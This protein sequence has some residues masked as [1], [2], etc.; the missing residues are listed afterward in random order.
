MLHQMFCL[1]F[2]FTVG[3]CLK[4]VDVYNGGGYLVICVRRNPLSHYSESLH[5]ADVKRHSLFHNKL[6]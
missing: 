3:F 1:F 4:C 2:G 6:K 5:L